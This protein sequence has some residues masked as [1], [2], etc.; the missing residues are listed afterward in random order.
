MSKLFPFALKRRFLPL[1]VTQFLGAMNDNLLKTA[2][3]VLITYYALGAGT[4]PAEQLLNIGALTFILPYFLFS[5]LAGQLCTKYN[6]ATIARYVK[7][8][9]CLIMVFAAVG[10]MYHNVYILLTAL[11]LMGTHSTF[12]GPIKY[13]ILPDYLKEHELLSGNGLIEL[14]TF[15]AILL[16]QMLGSSMVNA[17]LAPMLALLFGF[18]ILGLISSLGMPAVKATDPTARIDFNILKSTSVLLKDAY[19]QPQVRAAIVGISW[20]WL[21]G[22][23]YTTQLPTY[24]R[25]HLGGDDHVFSLMLALFSIGIGAGSLVCA[26]LSRNTLQLGLVLFGA[27]GMSIFGTALALLTFAFHQ[28]ELLTL[29][30]FLQQGKTPFI[31]ACIFA[32]GFFGGFFS[33]PLYTWLQTASSEAFRGHAVAANNIVNGL[34]MVVSALLSMVFLMFFHQISGLYLLVA[35]MN[36]AAMAVLIKLAPNIWHSRFDWLHNK[37]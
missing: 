5:A 14:G 36:L 24:T 9:E 11:F 10:F 21:L 4:L 32:L 19:R 31:T 8:V 23:T 35:L 27:V 33:V 6:K 17:D 15:L 30:Q 13:A 16:G 3:F 12:F 22:A 37:K 2:V 7:L 28:G 34:F 29:G 18:A 1:F 25:L 20:F 26:K